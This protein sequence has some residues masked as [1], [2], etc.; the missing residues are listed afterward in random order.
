MGSNW[1]EL[2]LNPPNNFLHVMDVGFAA[3]VIYSLPADRWGR[4]SLLFWTVDELCIWAAAQ[5]L[6]MSHHR[7]AATTIGSTITK[8]WR[9]VGA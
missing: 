5:T 9:N 2:G 7:I 1:A 3:R 8:F 4:S 6:K